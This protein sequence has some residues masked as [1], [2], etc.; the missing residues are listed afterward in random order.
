ML[1]SFIPISAA[2]VPVGSTQVPPVI[3]RSSIR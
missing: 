1:P 3:A 2:W